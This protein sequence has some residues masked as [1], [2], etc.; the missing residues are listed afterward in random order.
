MAQRAS[1]VGW[2]HTPF[3]KLDAPDVESLITMVS[4]S[5]LDHAGVAPKDVDFVSVGVFNNG[6]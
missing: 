3:G 4:R 5:A 2:S 6:L 1:I